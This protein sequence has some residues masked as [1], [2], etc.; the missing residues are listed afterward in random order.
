MAT[1]SN[2]GATKGYPCANIISISD[3]WAKN[4]SGIPYMYTT[5]LDLSSKDLAV[6]NHSKTNVIVSH[7]ISFSTN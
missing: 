5:P 7:M 6:R 4:H 1:I 2:R 3:G